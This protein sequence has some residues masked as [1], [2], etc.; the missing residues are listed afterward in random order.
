MKSSDISFY[1]VLYLVAVM[2]VFAIT[3]E[4]DRTL[5]QRN[6]MIAQLVAVYVRPLHVNAYVDTTKY[7]IDVT[8]PRMDDSV[9]VKVATEG[10]IVKDDIEFSLVG[11]EK[12][13]GDGGQRIPV[14]G[15][16]FNDHGD[17]VLVY[18]PLEEGSYK[19][20]V[21]GYKNRL[22]L[23]AGHMKVLIG[24]S[25]YSIPYSSALEKVD[26]DT[27]NLFI[28]VIK[29]GLQKQ[30]MTLSVTEARENWV[31]GPMFQ[32]KIFIGGVSTIQGITYNV[33][34]G[35]KLERPTTGES[36][37][38][39]SWNAPK[40]GKYSFTVSADA[41][42]GAGPKDRATASFELDVRPPVF[43]TPPPEKWFWGIPYK[44][45]GQIAGMNPL[46]LS[47]ESS[48]DGQPIGN[49]PVIPTIMI[50]PSRGWNSLAFSVKFRGIT[51]K[52]HKVTLTA[53]PPPQVKWVNQSLDKDRNVYLIQFTSSDASGGPVTASL[54]SQPSGISQVDKIRGTTFTITVNLRDKPVSVFLKLTVTDQYGGQ[55]T[56]S[57][58]FNLPTQ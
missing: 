32:K 8:A 13:V 6:Q 5:E 3:V 23:E 19:F 33:S 54:V 29:S 4:R 55:A 50:T 56:S 47:V 43:S 7:F 34:G 20:V 11:S 12:L 15:H 2:T 51:L 36:Y 1:F 21:S 31:V 35:G 44:F 58:Q 57:K 40:P 17:G 9:R 28:K 14:L 24:D 18:P 22:K 37:L 25:T 41:N 38:T 49:Q 48:H 45:D 26:R 27:T 53:P 30:Q 10:P 39:F 46:D 16:M 42:R 52:E